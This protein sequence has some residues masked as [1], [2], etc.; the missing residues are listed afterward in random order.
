MSIQSVGNSIKSRRKSLG[1][2]QPSL[3]SLAGV[4]TNTLYRIEKG[5]AN[6]SVKTLQKI[7]TI[8]GLEVG[9]KVKSIEA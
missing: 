2:T 3:A 6:P 5:L 1:V 7:A 8:L 9:L 4:S